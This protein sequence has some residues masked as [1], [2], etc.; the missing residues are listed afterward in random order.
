MFHVRKHVPTDLLTVIG[1]REI[2]RSLKTDSYRMAVRRSH[3]VISQM[4]AEFEAARQQVGMTVGWSSVRRQLHAAPTTQRPADRIGQ[5]GGRTCRPRLTGTPM[6]RTTSKSNGMNGVREKLPVDFLAQSRLGATMDEDTAELIAQLCTRAGM[7]MEDVSTLDAASTH[8]DGTKSPWRYNAE[9]YRHI[10]GSH[11]ASTS[12]LSRWM[13]ALSAI[14]D[15]EA[16][17]PN[18]PRAQVQQ[19]CPAPT[20]AG[21]S[22]VS[23]H[24]QAAIADAGQRKA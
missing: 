15:V 24:M 6:L 4:E 14:A 12:N 9:G 13:T 20:L 18:A 21:K 7:I 22:W 5:G 10:C 23:R 1:K 11:R 19:S 8:Q 2:W 3:F 16:R 17:N